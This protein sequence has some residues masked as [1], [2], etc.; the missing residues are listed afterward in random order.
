MKIEHFALNVLSPVEM[1]AWYEENMG[2]KIVRRSDGPSREH[3]L[4]DESGQVMLELYNNK[5]APVPNYESMSPLQL[6]LAF[7]SEKPSEDHERL[8][9]AGARFV[10]EIHLDDGSHLL[11]MRDPWGTPIQF[12]KRGKPMLR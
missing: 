7:V 11:M 4:A 10:E 5:N 8:S 12:C 2:L 6:H 1:A 9:R 3:F